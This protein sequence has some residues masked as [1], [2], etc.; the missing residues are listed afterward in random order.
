MLIRLMTVRKR[1]V[2][3]RRFAYYVSSPNVSF[4]NDRLYNGCFAY[5]VCLP[6]QH[7]LLT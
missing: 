5:H 2:H 7:L 6:Y 3:L 4:S 1:T